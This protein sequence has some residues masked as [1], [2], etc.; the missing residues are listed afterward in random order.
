MGRW[1]EEFNDP[2]LTG[3]IE[4]ALA[5]N[6]TLKEA[7]SRLNQARTVAVQVGAALYP[8]FTGTAGALGVF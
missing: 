4:E 5:D 8:D 6:L 7:W 1:W 2:E 3:L